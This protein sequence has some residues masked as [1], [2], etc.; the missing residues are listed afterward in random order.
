M[1][2]AALRRQSERRAVAKCSLKS[3]VG[4]YVV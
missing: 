3:A 2:T 4:S 1:R